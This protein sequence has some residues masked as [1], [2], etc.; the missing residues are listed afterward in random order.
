MA[1]TIKAPK[2]DKSLA[3]EQQKDVFLVDPTFLKL[4]RNSRINAEA[5]AATDTVARAWDIYHNGQQQACVVRRLESGELELIAGRGRFDSVDLIRG[6]FEYGGELFQD[7]GRKLL[8]RVDESIKTDEQAFA[9]S[10]R[11]NVRKEVSPIN[12]ASAQAVLRDDFKW[13]DTQIGEL[14]G[15]N[16]TNAIG[17]FKK[18]LSAP[19]TVQGLVHTGE[20]SVDAALK[21][22][23]LPKGEQ[24]KLLESGEK[25]TGP[26]IV[27]AI[28][29]HAEAKESK[30]EPKGEPKG[31]DPGESDDKADPKVTR[32]VAAFKKWV[33][34]YI[35]RSFD[36]V[37]LEDSDPEAVGFVHGL[38]DFFAGKGKDQRLWNRF[39]KLLKQPVK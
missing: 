2:L 31:N 38:L 11:E 30:A 19:A 23:T 39:E 5:G 17:R 7:A 28:A 6:G 9:A 27:E 12:I 13:T 18:L 14:Y 32:N 21:L 10:I 22:V 25:L 1:T 36:G 37:P 29:A 16:N 15:Y 26:K 4:G 33:A 34:E 8:V 20:L 35:D 3:A 24:A